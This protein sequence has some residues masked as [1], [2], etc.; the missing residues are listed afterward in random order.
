[1]PGIPPVGL[2][3]SEGGD[4]SAHSRYTRGGIQFSLPS[5]HTQPFCPPKGVTKIGVCRRPP[6]ECN[7]AHT[8]NGSRRRHGVTLGHNSCDLLASARTVA[9]R[10]TARTGTP[11]RTI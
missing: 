1:M 2:V 5:K 11:D 6:I 9:R 10:P 8:H 3:H 4:A 7:P